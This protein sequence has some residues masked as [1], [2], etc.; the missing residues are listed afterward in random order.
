VQVIARGDLN[1]NVVAVV[2]SRSGVRG[3]EIAAQAGLPGIVIE[4]KLFDSD[5]SFSDAIYAALD[6][7]AADLIICAGFLKQLVIRNRWIGRIL[8]IHPGLIGESDAAGKGFYGS[9]VHA[10]V[11][12]AGNAESG[13]TVHVVDDEYDH[14]PVVMQARVPVLPGDTPEDLAARVFAAEC[15]LYP[16]AIA[17]YVRDNPDLFEEAR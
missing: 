10:R 15:E 7:F 2:S 6:P 1:A 5:A 14:G 16:R 9:R 17:V 4:R 3:L 11:I 12:A 13:A 8:N